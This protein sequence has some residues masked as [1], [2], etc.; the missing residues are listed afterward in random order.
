MK[1]NICA[2]RYSYVGSS[3]TTVGR[4]VKTKHGT[5]YD[6]SQGTQVQQQTTKISSYV[7]KVPTWKRG[8]K[9]SIEVD[10]K[11]VKFVVSTNQAL[12]VIENQEFRDLLPREYQAP[13]RKTFTNVCLDSCFQ[14]T[15]EKIQADI[16]SH[17]SSYIGLQ[18]DHTTASN[19]GP[20][21]SLCIQYIAEDFSL[22]SISLGTFLYTGKHTA[23]ALYK[24]CEGER[25]GER[26]L[27][28]Q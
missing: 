11:I 17:S 2:Q 9:S 23:E 13:N 20:Y 5:E 28:H 24:S 27:I 4:H 14:A 1:C 18:V 15:K 7:Q 21:C 6:A 12:S 19:Y 10:R 25:E 26:G 3:T 16:C 22:K 8:S